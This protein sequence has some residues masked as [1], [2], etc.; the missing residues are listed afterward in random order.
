[1]RKMLLS[2]FSFAALALLSGCGDSRPRV[3]VPNNPSG[4]N[5]VG[6]SMS[7]PS[8]NLS[9][10][11]VFTVHGFNGGIFLPNSFAAVGTFTADGNG[12]ITAGTRDTVDDQGHQT[13]DEAI[14]GSYFVNG[15]GRGQAI[16][17]GPSGQAIYRFVLSSPASGKLFQDGTTRDGV[18]TDAVG[19]IELQTGAP[20]TPIGTYIVRLDGEDGGLNLFGAVGEITFSGAALSGTLD[21]ND[22][23]VFDSMLAA[24]GSIALSASRGTA[25]ITTPGPVNHHFVVY[26]VSPTRIELVST[27]R[28]FFL[29]GAAEAQTSFANSTAAFAAASPE[30]VFSLSG[31]DSPSGNGTSGPRAEVGRMTLDSSGNLLNA[32]ED[33]DNAKN[34]GSYF[35][36]VSLTGS[37]YTVDA[38]TGRWTANLV[39]SSAAPSPSLVGWQVSPQRSLVLTTDANILETG[40]MVAQTLGLTTADFNGNFTESFSGANIPNQFNVEL[41]GSFFLNGLGILNGTF[42]SQDDNSGLNFDATSS[43]T[44]SIDPT[45]GRTTGGMLE[46]VPVVYYAVDDNTVDFLSAQPGSIYAGTLLSQAP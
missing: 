16:L 32:I 40:T 42:D 29:N 4:G 10:T 35:A 38:A 41:T 9:G 22:G 19:S 37:R 36:G 5:N 6:F 18:I 23:G 3:L 20:A 39:N 27:D 1:M 28:S 25:T 44:Y 14:T 43:G 21:E 13:L 31:N 15:D 33:I 24:S 30:Q 8:L 26:F 17:N 46:G 45:L 12:N 11:Y 34:A 2:L 7:S